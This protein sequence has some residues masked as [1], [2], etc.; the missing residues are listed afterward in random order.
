MVKRIGDGIII[1]TVL[2]V[3]LTLL[4]F[5]NFDFFKTKGSAGSAGA[6]ITGFAILENFGIK[7]D[8][9]GAEVEN[10]L[11]SACYDSDN[12]NGLTD[13]KAQIYTKGHVSSYGIT[14]RDVC[15]RDVF[16]NH[17]YEQVCEPANIEL[18]NVIIPAVK[19]LECPKGTTCVQGECV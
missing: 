7:T 2:V 8:R 16:F 19:I 13:T 3:L 14:Y 11:D 6:S 15:G 9:Q 1:A 17:V 10:V 4:S 12:Y 5:G 18:V